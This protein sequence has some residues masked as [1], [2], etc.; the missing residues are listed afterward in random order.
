MPPLLN[1]RSV[2]VVFRNNQFYYINNLSSL[3]SF[4]GIFPVKSE[5]ESLLPKT[6]FFDFSVEI[7]GGDV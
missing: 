5:K 7:S 3:S 2:A 4:T 1:G 6:F